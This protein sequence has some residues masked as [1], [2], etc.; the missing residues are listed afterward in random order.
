MQSDELQS[1]RTE[2]QNMTSVWL[3]LTENGELHNF[4]VSAVISLFLQDTVQV[5]ECII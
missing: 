5:F 3:Q 1:L 4:T 2:E